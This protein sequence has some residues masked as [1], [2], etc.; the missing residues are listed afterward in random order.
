MGPTLTSES[1]HG[2]AEAVKQKN[3]PA[4]TLDRRVLHVATPEARG[5][6]VPAKGITY[7]SPD[8][9][10]IRRTEQLV[11]GYEIDFRLRTNEKAALRIDLESRSKITHEMFVAVVVRVVTIAALRA[12]DSRIHCANTGDQFQVNMA[13]KLRRVHSVE[14][15]K[16][17]TIRSRNQPRILALGCFPVDFCTYADIVPEKH[18][19]A[20]PRISATCK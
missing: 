10:S 20:E 15:Q 1:A 8:P 12:I 3:P 5:L 16:Y 14:V 9:R 7:G 17:G 4:V 13:G 6:V 11:V 18:I 2:G 19:A